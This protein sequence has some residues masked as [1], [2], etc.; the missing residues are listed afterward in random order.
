MFKIQNK[1]IQYLGNEVQLGRG[2]TK[3][4]QK[5]GKKFSSVNRQY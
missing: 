5:L 4:F 2:V 1:R 3:K